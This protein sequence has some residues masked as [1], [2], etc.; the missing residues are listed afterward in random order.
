MKFKK[1]L[2]EGK[3]VNLLQKKIDKLKKE[4]GY[5]SKSML[6]KKEL[7]QLKGKKNEGMGFVQK[8]DK[9]NKE[10]ENTLYLRTKDVNKEVKL[11]VKGVQKK[12]D[13]YFKKDLPNLEPDILEIKKGKRYIKINRKNVSGSGLSVFAFIDAKKGDTY[14]DI[15]KPASWKAP[16]KHA[17]GNVFDGNHGIGSIGVY[18]PA[19]LDSGRKKR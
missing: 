5:F 13:A 9:M 11:L 4:H 12:I 3:V 10:K 17:R 2:D 8:L 14:G 15:L 7:E 1:Y 19:Y 6:T 18:G 16:A